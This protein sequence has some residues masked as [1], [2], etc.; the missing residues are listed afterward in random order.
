MPIN[1]TGPASRSGGDG[2]AAFDAV[3]DADGATAVG[4]E[5]R[6]PMNARLNR[7]LPLSIFLHCREERQT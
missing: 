1:A 6:A 7:G 2:A 5:G 3:A 4:L